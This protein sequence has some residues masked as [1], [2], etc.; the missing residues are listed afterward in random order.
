MA[1]V[2]VAV[3]VVPEVR[4]E[5]V[6]PAVLAGR[7]EDNLIRIAPLPPSVTRKRSMA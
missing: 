2:P 3:V 4:G 6:D 1:V 5:Q 7:A